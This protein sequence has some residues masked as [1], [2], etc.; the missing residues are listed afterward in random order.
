MNALKHA[1]ENIWISLVERDDGVELQIRRRG[2]RVRY[3]NAFARGPLRIRD[4]AGTGACRG[5][6]VL[7]H[8]EIGRGTTIT[9][10]FPRVWVEEATLLESAQPTT[11]VGRPRTSQRE[12]SEKRPLRLFGRRGHETQFAAATAVKK[13][14]LK[15]TGRGEL[16]PSGRTPTDPPGP[17]EAPRDRR[18]VPA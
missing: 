16:Q 9:A 3:R 4:D 17:E 10:G 15:P 8:S 13:P 18:P 12:G 5:R 11:A 7:V 6:N 2:A 1:A 14:G